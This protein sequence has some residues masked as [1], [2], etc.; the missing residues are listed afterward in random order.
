VGF[1]PTRFQRKVYIALC[2]GPPCPSFAGAT[3]LRPRRRLT[4]GY[5]ARESLLM[6]PNVRLRPQ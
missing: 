1:E 2:N 5:H 3:A 6:A 4:N